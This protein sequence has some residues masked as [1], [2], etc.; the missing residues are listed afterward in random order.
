M[1]TPRGALS[2]SSTLISS[3]RGGAVPVRTSS[4]R[5]QD[6]PVDMLTFQKHRCEGLTLHGK[7]NQD[8]IQA[9]QSILKNAVA[10]GQT[11]ARVQ[12]LFLSQH[13]GYSR[14]LPYPKTSHIVYDDLTLE[15]MSKCLTRINL[16]PR[17]REL[18]EWLQEQGVQYICTSLNTSPKRV[19]GEPS[20]A[21][22]IY[23]VALFVPVQQQ[24]QQQQQESQA[25]SFPWNA[26]YTFKNL[27][28]TEPWTT[29]C[30]NAIRVGASYANI[31]ILYYGMDFKVLPAAAAAADESEYV[32]GMARLYPTLKPSTKKI[33][34]NDKFKPLI[35]W[36]TQ[37]AYEWTC[38]MDPDGEEP[39]ATPSWAYF[40]VMLHPLKII[41]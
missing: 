28:N 2:T 15:P 8:V 4:P 14:T 29:R 11:H 23:I 37:A 12:T 31:C 9:M 18:V 25:P 33:I 13:Y 40:T 20:L 39:D 30:V 21:D 6:E 19:F 1:I 3:P 16:A 36:V 22:H 5:P 38:L 24:Q 35:A 34:L 27:E 10:A 17:A 26:I 7:L 41:H 32:C